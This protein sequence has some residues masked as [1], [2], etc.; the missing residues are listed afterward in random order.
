MSSARTSRKRSKGHAAEHGPERREQQHPAI[1]VA[2]ADASPTRRG[3]SCHRE[4]PAP[5]WKRAE[6]QR[7][8]ALPAANVAL[9]HAD[10]TASPD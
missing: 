8:A 3:R 1:L 5:N 6:L 7:G 4:P 2:A 9:R 10:G